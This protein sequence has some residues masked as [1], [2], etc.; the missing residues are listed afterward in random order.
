MWSEARIAAFPG[1]RDDQGLRLNDI[2]PNGLRLLV[3]EGLV[4]EAANDGHHAF[5]DP[6]PCQI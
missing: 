2:L 6:R 3:R 1:D 5:L 4:G